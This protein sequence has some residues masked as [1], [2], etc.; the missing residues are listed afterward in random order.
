VVFERA[1]SWLSENKITNSSYV[2]PDYAPQGF[3]FYYLKKKIKKEDGSN[4][5]ERLGAEECCRSHIPLDFE[6]ESYG[7]I[8]FWFKRNP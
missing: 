1:D 5:K 2:L 7:L 6:L 4:G 3:N 8:L